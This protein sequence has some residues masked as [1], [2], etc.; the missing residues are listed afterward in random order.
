MSTSYY[1]RINVDISLSIPIGGIIEEK[2]R[3]QIKY[4]LESC[5]EI[6][7]GRKSAGWLPLFYQSPYYSNVEGIFN[8]YY[9]HKEHITIIDEYEREL[10]MEELKENLFEWNNYNPKAQSHLP[11]MDD[12]YL[13]NQGFEFSMRV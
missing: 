3:E 8:F 5:A 11:L 6:K 10:S 12:V 7:I 13:D 4:S 1:F 9:K 2:I